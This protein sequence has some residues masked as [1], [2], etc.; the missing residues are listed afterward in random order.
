MKTYI[1]LMIYLKVVFYVLCPFF[2]LYTLLI[3]FGEQDN[4]T[5]S[6]NFTTNTTTSFDLS[7][8]YICDNQD[9]YFLRQTGNSL[10]W[11]GTDKDGSHV[12]NI[13]KGII[14]GN[15][16]TGQWIDSPLEKTIGEGSLT[17]ILLAN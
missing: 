12:T 13:F 8:L 17:L 1:D 11:I 2:I 9:K 7:G 5:I 6:A 3:T 15:N 10:W 4:S 16:I 14:D